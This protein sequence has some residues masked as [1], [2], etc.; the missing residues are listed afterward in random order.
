MATKSMAYDNAAYEAVLPVAL[1]TITGASGNSQ[2]FAAFTTM[3]IKSV[4][5]KTVTAGTSASQV[6]NLFTLSGTTTTTTA[7]TTY[8]SAV[9]TFTN[10]TTTLTMSQGDACWISKGT[11]ATDVFACGLEMVILPGANVTA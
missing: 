5:L 1:G 9:N 6:L 4:T 3:L 10:V 8:G 11:D 2:R 7:L